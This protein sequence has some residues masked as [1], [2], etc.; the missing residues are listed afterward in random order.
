MYAVS[1]ED[2]G[3]R[4]TAN[5]VVVSCGGGYWGI[6]VDER[7]R[8]EVVALYRWGVR[9]FPVSI[10]QVRILTT[11]AS[12]AAFAAPA[13]ATTIKFRRQAAAR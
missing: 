2:F 12:T 13:S 5:R 7:R 9:T 10:G 6:L 8:T 11:P 1:Q 3:G 4:E